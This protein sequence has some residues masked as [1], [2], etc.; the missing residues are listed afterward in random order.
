[1]DIELNAQQIRHGGTYKGGLPR[2]DSLYIIISESKAGAMWLAS[3]SYTNAG[4]LMLVYYDGTVASNYYSNSYYYG[5]RPLVCLKSG[6]QLE[7]QADG[8]YK[9]K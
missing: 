1:M 3:P 7:L 5:F 2:N 9:I 6:V 4:D 8:S